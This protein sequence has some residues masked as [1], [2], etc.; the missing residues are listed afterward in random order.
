[1]NASIVY[2]RLKM[3]DADGSPS[4]SKIVPIR[5]DQTTDTK[6]GIYPNPAIDF[7]VLKLYSD[8][9]TVAGMK[10]FD[11]AGRQ[12][13][14]RSFTVNTGNNSV[15]IDKLNTLPKGIYIVQVMLNN[16]LHNEKLI[17]R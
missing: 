14:S 6:I 3:V 11:E 2:Y 13:I 5:L 10:L 12:I 16:T 17:K 9:Q 4:Y 15:L 7:A 8:K 1:V